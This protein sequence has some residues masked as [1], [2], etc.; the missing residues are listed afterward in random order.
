[1]A[2]NLRISMIQTPILWENRDGNLAYFGRML[3][4]I[5]GKTDLAVLPETFTTGFSMNVEALGDKVDGVTVSTLKAWA[6]KY[7]IAIA[8]SFIAKVGK[9]YFNRGF[10]VTPNG[11]TNFY[12]KRHLFRMS[13]EADHY[14]PGKKLVITSYKGWNICLQICYDLRFPVWS[15]NVDNKFDLLIYVANWPA[16]RHLAWTSLLPARAIEN[17]AYVCGVN[18]I[19][20]D[21]L[22]FEYKGGSAIYSPKGEKLTDT[23]T[24]KEF[25]RTFAI[26]IE[27][28]ERLRSKFPA[29]KD[30]DSFIL[31]S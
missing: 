19:G 18:C 16:A 10:L 7:Q 24:R 1:M 4:R 31:R 28:L 22:G 29:W 11:E 25:I 12:D 6:E 20:I 13:G 5:E 14:T 23:G 3:Q 30:A 17:L 9:A 2:E 8:G 27:P 26:E 15:R 21:G